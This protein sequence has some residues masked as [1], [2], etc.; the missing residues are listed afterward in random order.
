MTILMFLIKGAEAELLPFDRVRVWDGNM[1]NGALRAKLISMSPVVE[2]VPSGT[3]FAET[4]AANG[5]EVVEGRMVD[6]FSACGIIAD[7]VG[8]RWGGI[9]TKP[10]KDDPDISRFLRE[11]GFDADT[12]IVTVHAREA[13]FRA[14]VHQ[15]L[16]NIDI[17]A[18]RGALSVLVARGYRIV[19]LGDASMTPLD[20]ID[21]VFDYARSSLKSELMDILLP[22][23]AAFHIGCASGLS[24]VPLL[25]GTPTLYL[26]WNSVD[27]LPWDRRTWTVLKPIVHGV[28]GAR[29]RA[30]SVYEES[31]DSLEG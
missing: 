18:Y 13:G 26:N 15:T 10:T 19:R 4:F 23:I 16:R 25:Y 22:G 14:D 20:G 5:F 28:T 24:H 9:L 2:A 6:Q 29:V 8:D 27:L 12:P 21:G 30:L 7:R 17:A 1:A 3:Q 11:V 31:G